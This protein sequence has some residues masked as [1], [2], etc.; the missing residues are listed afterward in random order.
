MDWSAV[1]HFVKDLGFPILVAF[2]VLVR[3]NGKMDRLALAL[4]R[5]EHAVNNLTHAMHVEGRL[6][7]RDRP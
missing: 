3:L 7:Y 5:L 2:F 4:G 6:G 1:G